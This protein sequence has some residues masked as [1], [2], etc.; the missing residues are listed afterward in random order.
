MHCMA[1][2]GTA[3]F[4]NLY[5]NPTCIC[6]LARPYPLV[7]WVVVFFSGVVTHVPVYTYVAVLERSGCIV[8]PPRLQTHTATDQIFVEVSES[9]SAR[10]AP[11]IERSDKRGRP[12]SILFFNAL[13]S[14]F[15]SPVSRSNLS[16]F[17]ASF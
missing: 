12:L 10:I 5:S 15:V 6:P 2:A 3:F 16:V 1:T 11:L 7:Q 4:P 13:R 9:T 8:K 17:F 14:P